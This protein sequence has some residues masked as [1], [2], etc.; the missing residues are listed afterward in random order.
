M[1]YSIPERPEK[2]LTRGE[3]DTSGNSNSFQNKSQLEYLMEV[4]GQVLASNELFGA[5]NME[6][7]GTSSQASAY[8][9]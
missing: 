9:G 7:L 4:H 5:K 1:M 2:N 8:F 3:L 6:T